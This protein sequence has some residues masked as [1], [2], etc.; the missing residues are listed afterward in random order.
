MW[1]AFAIYVAVCGATHTSDHMRP[2]LVEGLQISRIFCFASVGVA[3]L[4]FGGVMSE[5][6]FCSRSGTTTGA[7]SATCASGAQ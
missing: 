3:L 6:A 5:R 4:P 1:V 7:P 2:E